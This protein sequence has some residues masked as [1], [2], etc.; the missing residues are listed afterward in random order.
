MAKSA[1]LG[2]H[3]AAG[4]MGSLHYASSLT[5]MTFYFT[6]AAAGGTFTSITANSATHISP[7][8]E[9]MNI[10]YS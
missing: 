1:L 4:V 7:L 10:F 3:V 5:Y 6:R 2:T 8:K 9:T